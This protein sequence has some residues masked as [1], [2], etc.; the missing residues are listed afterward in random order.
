MIRATGQAGELAHV[1]LN[2]PGCRGVEWIHG[3]PGLEKDIRVLGGATHE[4]PIRIQCATPVRKH[5][6]LADHFPNLFVGKNRDFVELVR[7]A[8]TVEEVNKGNSG[9]QCGGLC[10]QRHILRL[11]NRGG[12]EHRETGRA[13]RHDVGVIPEDGQG[14]AGDGPRRH[15]KDSR[16][17]FPRDLEHVWNHEEQP[18]G[19]GKCRRE[20]AR[21]KSAV[22]R[23]RRPSFA[24]HFHH[25]GLCSP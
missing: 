9:F 19:R 4:R 11:L 3:F 12:G 6:V 22:N 18:L 16:R 2:N 23:T 24:L 14:L 25:Q 21:L 7:S 17:Q 20:G 8:E 13:R 5:Q 1:T 10:N 15:M